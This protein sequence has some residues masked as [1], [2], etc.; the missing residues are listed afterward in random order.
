MQF[1][2]DAGEELG[3]F[4]FAH[5]GWMPFVMKEDE[6]LDPVNIA[7]LGFGL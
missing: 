6:P 3:Y 2:G 5:L 4:F 1:T 7:F